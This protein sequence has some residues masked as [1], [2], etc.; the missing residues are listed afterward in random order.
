MCARATWLPTPCDGRSE[1]SCCKPER[2]NANY[3]PGGGEDQGTFEFGAGLSV[4]VCTLET[5]PNFDLALPI[6]C[7]VL[8]GA[9]S[10]LSW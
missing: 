9:K 1:V 2:H 7:N 6:T 10:L 8:V 3:Y 5:D 4:G